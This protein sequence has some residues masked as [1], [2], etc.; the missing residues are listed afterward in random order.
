MTFS[1]HSDAP[2]QW[3]DMVYMFFDSWLALLETFRPHLQLPTYLPRKAS[4][5]SLDQRRDR[6]RP[7]SRNR[8]SGR[9]PS[10]S[11][12]YP[13]HSERSSTP[14]RSRLLVRVP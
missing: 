9:Q 6:I 3:S 1:L 12:H 2:A 7:P 5:F 14:C 10:A 8:V 13:W 11:D 4:P